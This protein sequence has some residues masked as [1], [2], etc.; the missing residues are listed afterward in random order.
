MPSTFSTYCLAAV[1]I[2]SACTAKDATIP[3]YNITSQATSVYGLWVLQ[4]VENSKISAKKGSYLI[5]KPDNY[6]LYAGCNYMGGEA[7]ITKDSLICNPGMSTLMACD[8][9]NGYES[10]LSQLLRQVKTYQLNGSNLILHVSTGEKLIFKSQM[11][12]EHLIGNRFEVGGLNL[13]NGGVTSS[14]DQPLQTLHFG[15]DGTL[16]GTAGCNTYQAEYKIAGDTLRITNLA[17]TEKACQE[18]VTMQW[19]NAFLSNLGNT[20]LR[21]EDTPNMV[22][23]RA[24]DGNTQMTLF[25]QKK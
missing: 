22:T 20:P 2:L 5:L 18:A 9:D 16:K 3:P 14:V 11:P 15:T 1:V 24:F 25:E 12:S 19:E 8:N 21:I 10:Q 23:L 4:S 17:A 7:R 13:R 6:T